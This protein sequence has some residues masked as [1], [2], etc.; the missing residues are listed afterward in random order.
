M[1]LFNLKQNYI[2]SRWL[3]HNLH[4]GQIQKSDGINSDRSPQI[5]QRM[6]FEAKLFD[7]RTN[8]TKVSLEIRAR[9]IS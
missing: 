2:A 6:V 3:P 1:A 4:N 7:V 9:M 5:K 8:F